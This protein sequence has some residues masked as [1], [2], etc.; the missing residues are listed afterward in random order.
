MPQYVAFLRAIN[1]GGHTVKMDHLRTL[2][3]GLGFTDVATFIASGNVI[4][5]SPETDRVTLERSIE[6]GLQTALGYRVDT[7]IRTPAELAAAADHWPFGEAD[8]DAAH[9]LFIAFLGASPDDD[10]R[11]R[12][13]AYSS[14]VDAFHVDGREVYWLRRDAVGDSSF[15]GGAMEKAL[16]MAATVRNRRTVVKLAARLKN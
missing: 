8:R 1:V 12:L 11:E 10:A 5:D 14:P 15:A 13:L 6:N 3:E 4:F 9:T 7:F 16:G 2:F